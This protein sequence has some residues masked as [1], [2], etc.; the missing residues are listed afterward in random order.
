[1]SKYN[2]RFVED[3][4][5]GEA[6]SNSTEDIASRFLSLHGKAFN[7]YL[8]C[9]AADYREKHRDEIQ[10]LDQDSKKNEL[11][12][13][14]VEGLIDF[15]LLGKDEREAVEKLM[16]LNVLFLSR[17]C[18]RG[19]GDT[20]K[21]D[22]LQIHKYQTDF[23][24]DSYDFTSLAYGLIFHEMGH[25]AQNILGINGQT[26]KESFAQGIS[27]LVME[28]LGEADALTLY[29]RKKAEE[30]QS[31]KHRKLATAALHQISEGAKRQQL[32]FLA[33]RAHP[34]S[35]IYYSPRYPWS[36]ERYAN[37]LTLEEL[38]SLRKV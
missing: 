31:L 35:K 5:I 9:L 32:E 11:K 7:D 22:L 27:R 19:G 36:I 16:G 15:G 29:Y 23:P 18:S 3:F 25:S 6:G 13:K 8:R 33:E 34:I 17:G 30:I 4:V 21:C 10:Q 20:V 1:M 26:I 14:L 12:T 37:P 38:K 28:H 24:A 2:H